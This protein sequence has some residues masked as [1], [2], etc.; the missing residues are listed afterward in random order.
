MWA[1]GVGARDPNGA[2]RTVFEDAC[3]DAQSAEKKAARDGDE[4]TSTL[5]LSKAMLIA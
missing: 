2:L 3:E 1:K 4:A 5:A